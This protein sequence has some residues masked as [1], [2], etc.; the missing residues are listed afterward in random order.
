MVK[1]LM[2]VFQAIAKY[3]HAT[4]VELVRESGLSAPVVKSILEELETKGYIEKQL[5]N[6]SSK[7]RN[8]NVYSLHNKSFMILGLFIDEQTVDI[9]IQDALSHTHYENHLYLKETKELEDFIVKLVERFQV[10]CVSVAAAGIVDGLYFYRDQNGSLIRFGICEHLHQRL[11]IPI[12]IQNDVKTMMIGYVSN[13][14]IE[15]LAYVYFSTTGVGSSYWF[16]KKMIQGV[17]HYSGELGMIP[18]H[19]KK[20]N[21]ILQMGVDDFIMK[22]IITQ[23]ITIVSVTIDPEWIVIAGKNIPF[24]LEKEIIAGSSVYLGDRY[25]LHLEFRNVPLHDVMEGVHYLGMQRLFEEYV[26]QG[27]KA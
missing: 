24:H 2:L 7:G 26:K 4:I 12:I 27:E 14:T 1:N 8:A 22:A 13:S 10:R 11:S 20:I 5:M 17:H 19:G 18:F 25:P 6:S 9:A 21:E 23:I 3:H 16:N 15:N